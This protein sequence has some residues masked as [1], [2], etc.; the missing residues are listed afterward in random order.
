VTA[1]LALGLLGLALAVYL[2]GGLFSTVMTQIRCVDAASELARQGA[3]DDQAAVERVS[4]RLPAGAVVTLSQRGDLVLARVEIGL[5]P[6]G[7]WFDP[8]RLAAEAETVRE[9]GGG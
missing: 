6:W 2:L 9:G 5:T 8:I 1:E 7:S 4:Q 3:R